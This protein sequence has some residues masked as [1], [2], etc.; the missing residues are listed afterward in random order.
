[1][2][3]QDVALKC[4]NGPMFHKSSIKNI[5]NNTQHG[6]TCGAKNISKR[7]ECGTPYPFQDLIEMVD[8]FELNPEKAED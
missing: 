6:E 5:E 4:L 2:P 3:I 8:Y 1:M 7:M